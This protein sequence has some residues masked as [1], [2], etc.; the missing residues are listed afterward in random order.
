MKK[1]QILVATLCASALVL[2]AC[3][4][5]RKPSK[6]KKSSSQDVPTSVVPGP[7]SSGTT[8]SGTPAPTPTSGT[9]TAPV[10]VLQSIAV[11][12]APTTTVYTAGQS[13]DPTGIVVTASYSDGST[14]NVTSQ[15]QFSPTVLTENTAAVTITFGGQSTTQAVT[16]NPVTPTSWSANQLEMLNYY[17]ENQGSQ[18]PF[19]YVAGAE[20]FRDAEYA[21]LTYGGGTDTCS[22]DFIKEYVGLFSTDWNIELNEL[23]L[24][25]YDVLIYEGSKTFNEGTT[26]EVT[27]NV[28]F[29][30][31]DD[32]G[33][34]TKDGTG[35]FGMD[36]SDEFYYSWE[37]FAPLYQ[38]A[39]DTVYD[40]TTEEGEAVAF[41]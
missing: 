19:K 38:E 23:A 33:Y 36:L 12:T 17:L 13:F 30:A 24:A 40:T 14:A 7:T 34:M 20:L 28:S 41:P 18:I 4:I 31:L 32:E 27:V 15:C 2:S 11:T 16:V 29:Y 21:C 3:T 26:S 25:F 6:K 35:H 9:S 8:T 37:E 22:E 10:K 5:G 1:S 39:L